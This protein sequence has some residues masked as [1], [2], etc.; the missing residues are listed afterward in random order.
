MKKDLF[1]YI[2]VP[3]NKEYRKVNIIDDIHGIAKLNIPQSAWLFNSRDYLIN[4][5]IINYNNEIIVAKSFYTNMTK[6]QKYY[7][8]FG[9]E[10]Y[11]FWARKYG[12]QTI[13]ELYSIYDKSM[14]VINYLYDLRVFP[15]INFKE[16][17]RVELKKI[18]KAFFKKIN[19]VY[20][21]LYGDKY[22]NVVRDDI[23]HNFSNLFFR[24]VPVYENEKPTGWYT[25]EELQY[26]EYKRIIDEICELLIENKNL[27]VE[28]L[29]QFYPPKGT[30]EYNQN[31]ERI[32]EQNKQIF[33]FLNQG[34]DK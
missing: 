11:D 4:A 16:N 9:N 31:I 5:A 8:K 15:D 20:S 29:K 32:K 34:G 28:K 6:Y 10:E 2:V 17:I 7:Q 21:R 3:T 12:E 18:D 25:Q 33:D 14:H 22:K 19:S 1:D 30:S 23:T 13:K 24:Y 26:S 27:I